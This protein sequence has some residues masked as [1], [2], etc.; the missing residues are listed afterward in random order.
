MFY[1][2]PHRNPATISEELDRGGVAMAAAAATL[3][4]QHECAW[5]NKRNTDPADV[6]EGISLGC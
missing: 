5:R 6:K 4:G 3:A 2:R 1:D